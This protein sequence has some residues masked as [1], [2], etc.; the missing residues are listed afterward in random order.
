M[1]NTQFALKETGLKILFV[2]G[3]LGLAALVGCLLP[4]PLS[5]DDFPAI[6]LMDAAISM[7]LAVFLWGTFSLLEPRRPARKLII[8]KW[9]CVPIV[10]LALILSL[11]FWLNHLPNRAYSLID[12]VFK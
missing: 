4:M 6:R 11:M 3:C 5:S 7:G 1:Q 8:A 2:V 12:A 9:V 10:W